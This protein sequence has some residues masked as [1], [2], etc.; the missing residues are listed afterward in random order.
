MA[1]HTEKTLYKKCLVNIL[2]KIVN[3][4][5]KFET[6]IQAVKSRIAF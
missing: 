3:I 5:I 6:L 2:A 4:E 1:F